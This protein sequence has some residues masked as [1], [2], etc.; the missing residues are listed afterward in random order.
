M[1]YG[2]PDYSRI[3]EQAGRQLGSFFGTKGSDP[4]TGV[5]DCIGYAYLTIEIGDNGNVHNFQVI[6]TWYSDHAGTNIVNTSSIG[7]MPGSVLSYQIPAV[8]R[9]ARVT[10]S[11]LVFGDTENVGGIAFGSNVQVSGAIVGP[12]A[13]PFIYAQGTFGAAT[14]NF[15]VANYTYWGPATL[16]WYTDAGNKCVVQLEYFSYI[17]AGWNV[18]AKAHLGSATTE[19]YTRVS[20]P[21]APVRLGLYNVDTVAHTFAGVLCLG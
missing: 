16:T 11:H 12:Q 7:H 3:S 10:I 1:T 14:N 18:I 6:V 4:T 20:L 13:Q 2:Y 5:M 17:T 8:S 21:P 19:G 15:F 9:Y